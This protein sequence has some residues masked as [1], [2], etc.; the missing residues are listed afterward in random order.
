MKQCRDRRLSVA[1]ILQHQ[2]AAG[3]AARCDVYLEDLVSGHLTALFEQRGPL[4]RG[5]RFDQSAL[6]EVTA[7]LEGNLEHKPQLLIL[8]KFGKAE[9]EGGGLR[10]LIANAL[11]REIPVIIGVPQRNL[12][13]WRSFAGEFAI[14]LR[15]EIG[16]I[17]RWL[18]SFDRLIEDAAVPCAN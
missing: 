7:R 6:A 2:V 16:E 1:G 8:T 9:I 12:D 17:E 15:P 13:A 3:Y 11:D 4:A 10:D 14:E 5:C 18:E